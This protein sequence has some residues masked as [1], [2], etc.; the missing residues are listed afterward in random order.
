MAIVLKYPE[1]N[2]RHEGMDAWSIRQTG[3]YQSFGWPTR[4]TLWLLINPKRD[5]AAHMRVKHLLKTRVDFSDFHQQSPIIGLVVLSTY[6]ANWRT[7]MA[8]YEREELRMVINQIRSFVPITYINNPQA[9]IVMS[10][11][12]HEKL[13]F[14]HST[15]SELRQL[16]NR[17]MLLPSI[18]RSLI[19]TIGKLDT[20]VDLFQAYEGAPLD[21]QRATKEILENYKG[22][23]EEYC[24]NAEFILGKVRTS[25]QLL[26]DTLNLKHQRIAQQISENTLVLSNSAARDSSTIHVIT[27]VT[28]LYLPATFIAVR[29][30]EMHMRKCRYSHWQTL[31][32]MQFFATDPSGQI[33]S[34][35]QLW[36]FFALAI[37]FTAATF[38]YWKWME[39]KQ[40][41]KKKSNTMELA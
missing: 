11:E 3:I 41:R 16:E 34:V 26:L 30:S 28:L 20:F 29:A 8:F 22:L 17:L 5:S 10:A 15:L 6:F 14:S 35:T 37:P 38:G 27:I 4:T 40:S 33:M 39:R 31:F 13:K 2:G 24:Q 23:T 32:G 21:S 7:L 36:K 18:F 12:V 19:R 9:G 1:R 25:A